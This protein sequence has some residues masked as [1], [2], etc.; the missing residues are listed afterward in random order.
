MASNNE[1]TLSLCPH[2]LHHDYGGLR[3]M[4]LIHEY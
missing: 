3:N 1:V 4:D 2:T